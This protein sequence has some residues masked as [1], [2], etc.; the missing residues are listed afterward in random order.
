[1][2]K[3]EHRARPD[4]SDSDDPPVLHLTKELKVFV[5]VERRLAAKYAKDP[6]RELVAADMG[7]LFAEVN[8]ALSVR[9]EVVSADAPI[10]GESES[11]LLDCLPDRR[12]RGPSRLLQQYHLKNCFDRWLSALSREQRGGISRRFG[13][14]GF[15]GDTLDNVGNEIGLT[16]KRVRQIQLEAL[17]CLRAIFAR[18][19]V[20][21]EL[22]SELD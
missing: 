20:A 4:E 18:E 11:S 9:Q 15:D 3:A 19:G 12:P 6:S 13:F 1:M 16:R 8:R 22:L 7:V 21:S 17:N 2:D 5:K 10:S 14:Y